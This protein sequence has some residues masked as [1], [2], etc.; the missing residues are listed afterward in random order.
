MASLN[1]LKLEVY[2]NIIRKFSSLH[3]GNTLHIR[4]KDSL[5]NAVYSE[6]MKDVL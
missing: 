1:P 3:T 6:N 4:Y 2:V 5:V